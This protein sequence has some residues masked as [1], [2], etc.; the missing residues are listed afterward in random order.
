MKVSR[1]LKMLLAGVI[2]GFSAVSSAS[3]VTD[4]TPFFSIAPTNTQ[5]YIGTVDGSGFDLWS[6]NLTAP[7]GLIIN[8][9]N[10]TGNGPVTG[11]FTQANAVAQLNNISKVELF[12]GSMSL[13]GGANATYTL[14]GS[15]LFASLGSEAFLSV[16]QA[17]QSGMYYL[18]ISGDA[19]TV[20]S[21]SVSAVPLP[22]A[23]WLFGSALLG[24]G[25][26]RRKQKAGDNSEMA[27][28]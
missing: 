15:Q 14:S 17:F 26:M 6:I 24:L 22:A 19:G 8:L 12:D 1:T 20:Y 23:A 28:A 4:V 3:T 5:N 2:L 16:A 21:G 7:A 25:A 18:K 13:L 10:G 9:T 11:G 27:L